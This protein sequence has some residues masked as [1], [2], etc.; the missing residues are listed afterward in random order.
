MREYIF[1][2]NKKIHR[3]WNLSV[4]QCDIC[5][6]LVVEDFMPLHLEWHRQIINLITDPYRNGQ[7]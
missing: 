7:K 2:L 6:A 3:Y 5:Q 4:H 1:R